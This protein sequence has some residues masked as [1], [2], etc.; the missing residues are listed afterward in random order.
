MGQQRGP[1]PVKCRLSRPPRF[2]KA[3]PARTPSSA[4]GRAFRNAAAPLEP[5][6][7]QSV[8]PARAQPFGDRLLCCCTLLWRLVLDQDFILLSI[9]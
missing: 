8:G 1:R 3:A 7:Q 4:A 5:T 6:S 9:P 2:G